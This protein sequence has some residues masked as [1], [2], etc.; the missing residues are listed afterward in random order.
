[1][2]KYFHLQALDG[3]GSVSIHASCNRTFF[4]LN[5][6]F[7]WCSL[8]GS[9][10]T[11][12]EQKRVGSWCDVRLSHTWQPCSCQTAR[13]KM[14]ALCGHYFMTFKPLAASR[15]T[16][17]DKPCLSHKL[18]IVV[19]FR[20]KCGERKRKK[21]VINCWGII[22]LVSITNICFFEHFLR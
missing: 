4:A 2:C 10:F 13:Q 19:N 15:L 21:K 7:S 20:W 12:E 14:A 17:A 16:T 3:G 6:S 1:M 22:V 9:L 11:T 8:L 18:F 5:P